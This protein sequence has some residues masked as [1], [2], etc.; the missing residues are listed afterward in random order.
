V[1]SG[2]TGKRFFTLIPGAYFSNMHTSCGQVNLDLH[3]GLKRVSEI[4]GGGYRP[5]SV[6]AGFLA[7]DNLRYLSEKEGLHLHQRNIWSQYAVDNGDGE[8]SSCNPFYR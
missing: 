3:D 1:P 7:A 8:G 6:I 4:I 5:K 2:L